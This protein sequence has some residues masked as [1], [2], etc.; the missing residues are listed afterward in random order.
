[1]KN[2]YILPAVASMLLFAACSHKT[3]ETGQE[4]PTVDVARPTVDSIVLHKTYPGVLSANREVDIV[5]RV[6]G[7]LETKNYASGDRVQKGAVLFTIESG[8][9]RDALQRAE[10]AL[11]TALAQQQYAQSHYAALQRALVSEA[12]SRMEAE[13][14]RSALESAN[15]AVE[16]ARADIN[17]A[18]TNL[19]YCTVRAPFT[20]HITTGVHD[21][22]SYVGG[23]GAPVTLAKIYED[24]TM[25]ANF[26]VEDA[27][28]LP[29]IRQALGSEGVD[30]RAI[31]VSFSDTLGHSYTAALDY[32]A[33]AVDTSTG[34]VSLQAT[35]ANPYN[36]LRSGMY[37]SVDL[38]SGVAPHAVLVRTASIA[39]DQ[40]GSY[41]YTVSDSSTVVYTP[42]TL[43]QAVGDSLT[44]VTDGLRPD[45]RYVTRALLKVRPGMKINPRLTE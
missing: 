37:V 5:A 13:Q 32:L 3:H 11:E 40:R 35:I 41:L 4:T 36:E 1:M 28:V 33:P 19:G 27:S 12:V 17:S 24:D 15:S 31:P 25:I 8:S 2:L 34:T 42:V 44:I 39:R 38:P 10:A 29:L 30:Y 18:R 21:V 6:N 23:E 20:G 43:G 16:S 45:D 14:G 9:Y 22:G 26:S 7:T